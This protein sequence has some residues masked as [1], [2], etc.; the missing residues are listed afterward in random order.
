M[1]TESL[2]A[3]SRL[4][5]TRPK[6]IPVV[7]LGSKQPDVC[8]NA[9]LESRSRSDFRSQKPSERGSKHDEKDSKHGGKGGKHGENGKTMV[10]KAL[11][12]LAIAQVIDRIEELHEHLIHRPSVLH[13][14]PSNHLKSQELNIL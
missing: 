9:A 10:S 14:G 13:L 2:K 7:F 4:G 12:L 11:Q 8:T 3:T 1:V 5:I 6:P